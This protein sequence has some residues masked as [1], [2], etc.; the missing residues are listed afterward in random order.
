MNYSPPP[1]SP[2][3]AETPAGD[4]RP[5]YGR[6]VHALIDRVQLGTEFQ[7][8]LP[9]APH[10]DALIEALCG[11][12]GGR[13]RAAGGIVTLRD[14]VL[15]AGAGPGVIAQARIVVPA[16]GAQ[17]T[18]R[19]DSRIIFNLNRAL[20]DVLDAPAPVAL[21]GAVNLVGY[22]GDYRP[23][24][25]TQLLLAE[26]AVDALVALIAGAAGLSAGEVSGRVWVQQ[27]EV[28]R[29]HRC[30]HAESVVSTLADMPV[31]GARVTRLCNINTICIAWHGGASR[32]R[33]QGRSVRRSSIL[34]LSRAR[35]C[36][37]ARHG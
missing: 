7:L 30:E 14:C 29:D 15:P 31:P 6:L 18:I 13:H 27:A 2:T 1:P 23:H 37:P 8:P 36:R 16:D 11:L 22:R 19:G 9:A 21:D 10:R 28:C 12:A 4:E 32:T 25:G 33:G 24:L 34:S 20:R 5:A 3:T 17:L 35:L 26:E